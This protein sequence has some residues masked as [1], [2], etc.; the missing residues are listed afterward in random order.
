MTFSTSL[1][2]RLARSTVG[3]AALAQ[4]Q[5]EILSSR[6]QLVEQLA[7][8]D[9]KHAKAWPPLVAARDRARDAVKTA[10]KAVKDAQEVLRQAEHARASENITFDAACHSR[11]HQLRQTAPAAIA[12]FLKELLELQLRISGRGQSSGALESSQVLVGD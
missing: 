2:E 11:E 9:R 4:E 10:E 12:D 1:L 7:E 8:L 5:A 6:R 3:Q